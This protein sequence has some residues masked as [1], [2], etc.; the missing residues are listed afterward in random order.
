MIIRVN[1][2][3]AAGISEG[4]LTS[5]EYDRSAM[6]WSYDDGGGSSRQ[7]I[8]PSTPATFLDIIA[9]LSPNSEPTVFSRRKLKHN[10]TT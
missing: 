9:I 4:L 1:N 2:P 3:T 5:L 8:K 7:P 10:R 6:P